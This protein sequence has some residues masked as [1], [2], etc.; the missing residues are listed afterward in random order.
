[1]TKIIKAICIAITITLV[2]SACGNGSIEPDTTTPSTEIQTSSTEPTPE[3]MIDDIVAPTEENS[4]KILVGEK[5]SSASTY[6]GLAPL[7]EVSYTVSDPDNTKGLST[8]KIS[9]S[10]G[11][12]SGGKAHHTVLEFQKTF[13]KYGAFTVD[14]KSDG[15]VLYLTFDCGYEHNNLTNR[16]LDTL[17]EKNVPAAFFCTLHHIKEQPELIARMIN[18]GHIVGNH[19]ASHPSFAEITRTQMV[20]EIE[21]CENYLRQNFGYAA[22]YFRF[23]AGEYNES[24]LDAINSIG[25][26]CS[27]WSVAYSDWDVNDIKGKDYAVNTIMDRLHPGAVILLHSVSQDNADALGEIIDKARAQGYEFKSLDEY[28][29]Q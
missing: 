22:K 17:K 15:K 7:E 26:V 14:T 5:S 8:K 16:V 20:E 28:K 19:S 25:Y 18:E 9:H 3:P 27:F 11:P 6:T 24:A 12:A 23:P 21:E 4:D 2:L 29:F 10:H 1:M 13:D